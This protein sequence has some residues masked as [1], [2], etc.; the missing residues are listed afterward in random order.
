M[1][2]IA[3]R[4]PHLTGCKFSAFPMGSFRAMVDATRGRRRPCCQKNAWAVTVEGRTTCGS[5]LDVFALRLPRTLTA[6]YGALSSYFNVLR[7]LIK[8]ATSSG[9]ENGATVALACD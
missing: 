6:Q 4:C 2:F 9:E 1:T 7:I 8:L 3:V 5:S